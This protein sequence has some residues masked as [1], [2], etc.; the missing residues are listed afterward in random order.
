M[1]K[2]KH[3]RHPSGFAH[4]R[5]CHPAVPAGLRRP[6][7]LATAHRQEGGIPIAI[8]ERSHYRGFFALLRSA[9]NDV[10][11]GM[12]V[13]FIL[14]LITTA[15]PAFTQP[16]I[17][18]MEYYV[19]NDLGFGLG[20]P[21]SITTGSLVDI[22]LTTVAASALP[23][24]FHTL[25]V[26]AKNALGVWGF[27]ERRQ[28][29]IPA[30]VT[31][32]NPIPADINAM[33]YYVDV[34]PGYGAGIAIV[35]T[36]GSLVDLPNE[37]IAASALPTGFHTLGIRTKNTDGIWGF[38]E[39]RQFYIPPAVT[40]TNPIPSD[41]QTL[42]YFFDVDPGFGNATAISITTGQLIDINQLIPETLTTGFHFISIRAM[43]TD[44][45]W[46]LSEKRPVYIPPAGTTGST[47]A[48]ITKIE[49]YFDGTDP[50]I[51]NAIDLPIT[52]GQLIDLNPALVP[53]SPTLIDGPHFITFRAMNANN[54]WGLA[55]IDTFDI[56]DNCTQP[57]AAF[58]PSL[59]CAGQS[60]TFVDNSTNLQPDASYRWYLN[61]D[62]IV[63][64]TTVADVTFNYP[65]PGTYVVA[66]A[67]RQG[68]ICL[69]SIA[70][71]IDIQ[72][73]PVA[74][75]ST[76]GTEANQTTFFT[77]SASN[78]PPVVTWDWDFDGD[79]VIDDNTAGNT[80]Y[81]YTV[82]GT[83]NPTLSI[84]DGNGCGVIVSNPI[85]IAGTGTAAPPFVDF[86]ADNSCVGSTI[87]FI[88]LSQNLPT[89]STYSWDFNGDGT[90]DATT[91]GSSSF[92]YPAAGSYDAKL[93]INIGAGTIEAFHTIEIVDIPVA[94]FSATD[95][96]EG[97]A[98]TFTDLSTNTEASAV[99]MW[100]FNNDGVIDSNTKTGTSYTFTSTGAQIVSLTISNGFGCTNTIVKQVN[101]IQ[102]PVPDFEWGLVCT[103]ETVSFNNL[104]TSVDIGATYSWDLDGD[105]NEDLSTNG[106]VTFTYAAKGT[107]NASLTIANISGCAVTTTKS[108]EIFDRPEV[109]INVLARCYGQESQMIDLSLKVSPTATYAWDFE[110]DGNIDDTTIGTTAFTYA[111]YNSYIVNLSIDNGGGCA[112]STEQLVVFS[113]AATPDF[114]VNKIC[115]GEPVIFTNLST[116]VNPAAI[117]SWDFDGDGLEDSAIPGSTDYI[118]PDAGLYNATLTIDNGSSCLA[119]KVIPLDVTPPPAVDL[120]PD[121]N[122]CV[123]GTVTFDAGTGYSAYL[124]PDGSTNQTYTIDQI[125]SYM[126]RVQDAKGCFNTD[127]IAVQLLGPPVPSF[128]FSFDLSYQGIKIILENTSANADIYAWTFGDGAT[129]TDVNPSHIYGEYSFYETSIYEVCLTATNDCETAQL[130]ESIF[131]SPTQFMEEGGAALR[132]FPNPV[133]D[134]LRIEVDQSQQNFKSM[135]LI[136]YQGRS[137]W[138]TKA[139]GTSYEL[140]MSEFTR[141][142]YLLILE[143]ED[144]LLYKRVIKGN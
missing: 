16:N 103:G 29:Y 144:K 72:P 125:G 30:P 19:D 114:S 99:Y 62:A 12:T 27:A 122:L 133:K 25:G 78:L 60:V 112:A 10:K 143:Q 116:A 83:Y 96:C 107:Y 132:V 44:G 31:I 37:I 119:T 55:E 135:A 84:S 110:G 34:D 75:F 137:V 17:T 117:Y 71:T 64:D 11:N 98:M 77:A 111:A 47:A 97:T 128:E 92:A 68:S 106:D 14:L 118:Y 61:G 51:G 28:F 79:T 8:R 89:G 108:I 43:N 2:I 109:N 63:D 40:L 82:E 141:G 138:R 74:V 67:I 38:A 120:G 105:G 20:T 48:D 69:D 76:S 13:V 9:L 45:T 26:R 36:T 53:T 113:D 33:E 130:C 35:V 139:S 5:P 121:L 6:K 22:P 136:D 126:V 70:T 73:L 102:L 57:I 88:D 100:D 7:P 90:E 54:V 101:I 58:T 65:F 52:P 86:L 46:G 129:S 124:W 134:F 91:L 3:T 123:A 95:V 104:S 42:E 50:G 115:E 59:A 21:I 39:K 18:A 81:I 85:T 41:I 15:L 140:N 131:V 4:K 24:G 80:S 93:I 32:T 66:L 94:D 56:L 49:Y 23:A 87:S 142:V 1:K 127:T